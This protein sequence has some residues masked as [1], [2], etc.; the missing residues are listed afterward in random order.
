MCTGSDGKNLSAGKV[1]SVLVMVYGVV[2]SLLLQ[3]AL[4]PRVT[5]GAWLDGECS[6]HG[7]KFEKECLAQSGV[8][9]VS[10]ALAT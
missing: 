3:Y 5:L 10:L 8:F 4:G 6:E 7:Q 9:R 1:G 2:L